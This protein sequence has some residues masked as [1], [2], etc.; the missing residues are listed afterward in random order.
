MK[1]IKRL[2]FALVVGGATLGVINF[3]GQLG[4]E[5]SKEVLQQTIEVTE[6][7]A[8]NTCPRGQVWCCKTNPS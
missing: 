8:Q 1:K 3:A 2:I 5:R 6:S 7:V 4:F